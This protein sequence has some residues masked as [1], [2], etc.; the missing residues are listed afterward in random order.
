LTELE[1][2]LDFAGISA[3]EGRGSDLPG[4]L[5]ISNQLQDGR[6]LE[7]E[8]GATPLFDSFSPNAIGVAAFDTL[9]RVGATWG[10]ASRIP[11][12]KTGANLLGSQLS[13]LFQPVQGIERSILLDGYRYF[14]SAPDAAANR[15]IL[16]VEA[17]EE[18]QA[19]RQASQSNRVASALRRLGKS[20]TMNQNREPLCLA[21]AHEL[22]SALE[23]AACL[24]WLTDPE[25]QHL[26]LCASVGVARHGSAAIR[27]LRVDG[28]S[29]CAAEAVAATR[30]TFAVAHVTDQTF[31]AEIEAK[32]CYLKPGPVSVHPLEIGGKLLGVLE[33]IGRDGDSTFW[34][35][36]DLFETIAEHL[37]LAIKNANLY[38]NLEKLASH[39]PLTALPNHR[40]MQDFLHAQ[41]LES[42]RI[43]QSLGLIMM[44]VDHF[45]AFNEEEGHDAGDEVLQLIA[46]SLRVCIRPYDI[47]A[48]YGGEEFVVILPSSDL[49]STMTTA[50]RLRIHIEQRPYTTKSGRRAHVS[51][52]IG[53][54]A[55]PDSASDA[56][57][58]L[59]AADVAMYEAK[60]AGRN[61]VVAYRGAFATEPR[62]AT[63]SIES[64]KPWLSDDEWAKGLAR[65]HRFDA[66]LDA[67][68]SAL[69]LSDS[70]VAMLRG[71]ILCGPIYRKWLEDESTKLGLAESAEEFRVLL[72]SLHSL[73][74]RFDG[75]GFRL[76]E[77]VRIPLLGRVLQVL[78]AIDAD[79]S[80][81]GDPGRFDPDIVGLV[82]AL[83]RA[84]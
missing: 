4:T 69:G 19:K 46:D 38:E 36:K 11:A 28:G 56:A 81:F 71:L 5:A 15:F 7:M 64:L 8:L 3:G 72:P 66:D 6:R 10:L 60:K 1:K 16:V 84:A 53:A 63:F 9:G 78:L 39:D 45:R 75:N 13:E 32:L 43:G 54:A 34:E 73:A 55:L 61:R 76:V 40:Y 48:R 18:F 49:A 80:L 33:L 67:L 52:S 21:A 31:T 24:L 35:S 68:R 70:Q 41:V 23:L 22:A 29:S 25:E 44:D 30:R 20:L 26:D 47:A 82:T 79:R 50:E 2:L 17:K 62:A 59:K 65:I 12:L 37:A 51:V 27:R 57:G 14:V 83:H 58:L 74:E 42:S 77:G